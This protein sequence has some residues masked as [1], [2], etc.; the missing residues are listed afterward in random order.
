[1]LAVCRRPFLITFFKSCVGA[2]LLV[3]SNQV[4]HYAS[5]NSRL[6]MVQVADQYAKASAYFCKLA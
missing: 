3:T 6:N 1:M 4:S 5:K 2:L